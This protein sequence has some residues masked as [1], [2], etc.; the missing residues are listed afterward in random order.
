MLVQLHTATLFGIDAIACEVEVNISSRGF[1]APVIVG[2]PDAAVKESL[3]RIRTAITNCGYQPPGNRTVINL[4][5]ADIR[6][7]GP[8]FDLPIALGM[9]FANDGIAPPELK[10]YVIVGELALDG[11]VRP[12]KGALSIAMMA[13][14]E[15]FRGVIVPR[16][17]ANEAAVVDGLEVI[18]VASLAEAVGFVVGQLPLEPTTVD[19]DQQFAQASA[20]DLDFADVR[21]Q[22]FAKRALIIAAA[23]GHNVLLVGPPGSGKTFMAKCLPTIL[24]A[25]TLAESL[26]TT[27]IWSASGKLP[28]GATLMATRPVRTPHHSASSPALV[29]GGTI[30][31]AGEVSLAHHGVLFLDEFPEFQRAILETLRQPM[32]DGCVTIARAHSVVRFPAEFMMVAAMNPC[33]CGY[34]SDPRKPC[35]CSQMQIERYR[36]RISGPLIDRIDIHITVPAVP[37]DELRNKK[38]GTD[39]KKMREEVLAAR[40]VQHARFAASREQAAQ[41]AGREETAVLTAARATTTMLN[42]RMGP[43]LVRQHCPLDSAGETILKQ[44]MTELGLSARAHDKVLRISRTIADLAGSQ[45]ILPEH[46]SEAVNYRQLDRQ[47]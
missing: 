18:A 17:N 37:F 34:L 38:V 47:R 22:E 28:S 24:P 8:A 13:Q 12:I 32:E 7:E 23:G 5:P 40:N 29:G 20:Y 26:E 36:A 33:P 6:K 11:R 41:S 15:G 43:K 4:A 39:S 30:P 3:E 9:I 25:L 27:R 21:G 2:L 14:S 46:V 19:L 45:R 42:A 16:E 44:A 1:A 10:E 31:Q 35:K